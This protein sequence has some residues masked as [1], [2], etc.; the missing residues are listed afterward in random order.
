LVNLNTVESSSDR[1]IFAVEGEIVSRISRSAFIFHRLD[2]YLTA[3][4][5][6]R[7]WTGLRRTSAAEAHW[8]N[9]FSIFMVAITLREMIGNNFSNVASSAIPSKKQRATDE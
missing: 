8:K 9:D 4:V 3:N 5:S 6:R 2:Q 7:E 1:T